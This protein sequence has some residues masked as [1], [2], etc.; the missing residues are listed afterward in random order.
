MS[1]LQMIGTVASLA[2]SAYA[3]GCAAHLPLRAEL[4]AQHPAESLSL[5]AT[6]ELHEIVDI[7]IPVGN[8]EER[9]LKLVVTYPM[10]GDPHALEVLLRD[11][12]GVPIDG[13]IDVTC[14]E[15]IVYSVDSSRRP[16]CN[17]VRDIAIESTKPVQ[18]VRMFV[19]SMTGTDVPIIVT[20][21]HGLGERIR[22]RKGPILAPH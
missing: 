19:R 7:T 18:P 4:T 2:A 21:T 6:S 8:D 14:G 5:R 3:L 20:L 22:V 11:S 1:D 17:L 16:A 12:L 10:D 15:G 13:T 9:E